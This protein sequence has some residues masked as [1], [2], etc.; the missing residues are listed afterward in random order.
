MNRL[1]SELAAL[2]MRLALAKLVLKTGF[3]PMQPRLPRGMH[4]GGQWVGDEAG[5]GGGAAETPPARAKRRGTTESDQ[6]KFVDTNRQLAE[7]VAK[8]L[9]KGA[10]ADEILAFAS[11]ETDWGMSDAAQDANN[12]FGLHNSENGPFPGQTGT[13]TTSGV[14]DVPGVLTQG[15]KPPLP[16]KVAQ[17]TMAA[18]PAAT[19]FVDSAAVVIDKL[20]KAGGDYSNP[21]TFF[22]TIRAHGW[23]TGSDPATYVRTLLQ[24]YARVSRH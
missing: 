21:A 1:Y 2:K 24:R 19:G 23:A 13:Y 9:G 14:K 18:F 16:D 4:G 7:R 5:G 15:W 3:D 6:R 8:M 20:Q 12:F 22:A 11:V 17:K 10:N